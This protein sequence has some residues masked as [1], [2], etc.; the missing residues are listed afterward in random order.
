MFRPRNTRVA[1]VSI[2]A[3][4]GLLLAASTAVPAFPLAGTA[5]KRKPKPVRV[6]A[7]GWYV[8]GSWEG[9]SPNPVPAGGTD[10]YCADLGGP[11]LADGGP[12]LMIAYYRIHDATLPKGT[13]GSLSGPVNINYLTGRALTAS[14]VNRFHTFRAT[15]TSTFP[16]G[17]YTFRLRRGRRTLVTQTINLVAVGNGT[18]RNGDQCTITQR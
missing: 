17:K 12:N 4:L 8:N 1:A 11:T 15:S 10:D 9:R 6:T 16:P 7:R 3:A 14:R 2:A 13:R 5:A 18:L